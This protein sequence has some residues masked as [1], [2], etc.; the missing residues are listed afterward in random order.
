MPSGRPRHSPNPAGA[1][2]LYRSEYVARV[3][4]FCA[5]G[6]SLTGFAGEIGVCRDTIAEWANVHAEFGY[7]C[8]HAKAARARWWEE[9]AR[10]IA[11][12]GGPGGQ[13]V[14]VIFGLKNHAPEDYSDRQTHEHSGHIEVDHAIED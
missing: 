14:M 6:Y 1:P 10:Q 5:E 7:A 4:A 12:K 3:I 11:L 2:T 13:A 9:Q 8:R